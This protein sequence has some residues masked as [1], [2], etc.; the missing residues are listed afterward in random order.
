MKSL[1]QEI[2]KLSKIES[3]LSE[4]MD[5]AK[6]LEHEASRKDWLESLGNLHALVVLEETQVD[7]EYQDK[8]S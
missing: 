7:D 2:G 4:A 3:L 1:R 5:V 8:A 6:T